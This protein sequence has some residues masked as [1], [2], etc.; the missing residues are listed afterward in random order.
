MSVCLA[1]MW[2]GHAWQTRAVGKIAWCISDRVL[3]KMVTHKYA[4]QRKYDFMRSRNF[5]DFILAENITHRKSSKA[6]LITPLQCTGPDRGARDHIVPHC[7]PR[8]DRRAPHSMVSSTPI[9]CEKRNCL[10]GANPP[11]ITWNLF[12]V[13]HGTY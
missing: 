2:D 8:Y 3:H 6:W 12:N 5:D 13:L 4:N 11:V 1:D 10:P 7:D 9:V